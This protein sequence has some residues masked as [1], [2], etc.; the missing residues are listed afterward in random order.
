MSE[1]GGGF[2]SVALVLFKIRGYELVTYEQRWTK[3][4]KEDSKNLPNVEL[5]VVRELHNIPI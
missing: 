3:R 4:M 5:D 2:R 1:G